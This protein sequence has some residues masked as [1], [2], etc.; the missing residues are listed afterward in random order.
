MQKTI[1]HGHR[2]TLKK[3]NVVSLKLSDIDDVQSRNKLPII[4]GGTNY[5]I[6]SLLWKVLLDMGVSSHA[7]RLKKMGLDSR[8][9]PGVGMRLAAGGR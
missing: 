3:E 2:R 6:E 1:K 9:Q 4:V 8:G 5:Y 7:P